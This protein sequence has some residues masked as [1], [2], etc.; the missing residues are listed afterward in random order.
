MAGLG[1]TVRLL[2]SLLRA[3][4]RPSA[5]LRRAFDYGDR[6]QSELVLPEP[7]TTFGRLDHAQRILENT[8]DGLILATLPGPSVGYLMLAGA[9]RLLRGIAAP[10][11]LE[12]V[13]R[14]LPNNVTTEMDLELWQLAVT[15]GANA[16]SREV[17][18]AHGP[19]E[20][21]ALYKAGSL[22]AVAQTGLHGF[23]DRYGHRAVAEIDLGMPRWSEKPDHI[24]GMISN[25][26]HV[27]D[28]EQAPDRQFARAEEH[29]EARIRSLVERI[30]PSVLT[31]LRN[32]QTDVNDMVVENDKQT[33]QRLVDSSRVI[34]GAVD[35]GRTA[36]IGLAYSLADGR[37]DLVSSIGSL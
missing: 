36:V 22:P 33:S 3:A 13:L 7:A 26:L 27:A 37:A 34:S 9:R 14:G 30:T 23:L 1:L 8:V 29:A 21:A 12:A 16:A 20:L 6:L 28:P 19:R 18:L 24:L 5:E 4:V 11:E 32:N 35:S 17:F 31:S 2:P 10:R 25:Y 15:I